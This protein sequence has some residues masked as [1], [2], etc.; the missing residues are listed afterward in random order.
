M[1]IMVDTHLVVNFFLGNLVLAFEVLPDWEVDFGDIG[2]GLVLDP[3]SLEFGELL[4]EL[5]NKH[6]KSYRVIWIQNCTK[7]SLTSLNSK[8][9]EEISSQSSQLSR[10][11]SPTVATE[12][13]L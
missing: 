4:D 7:Y 13:L 2:Q 9:L 8:M 1:W 11:D 12:E 10:E 6:M 3:K 5:P